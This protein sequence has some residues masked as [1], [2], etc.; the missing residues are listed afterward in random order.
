M[1]G[2]ILLVA[3]WSK[4]KVPL[5]QIIEK[6]RVIDNEFNLFFNTRRRVM[7]KFLIFIVELWA[8]VDVLIIM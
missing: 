5:P 1:Y 6:I 4:S 2:Q 7:T 8:T 3:P